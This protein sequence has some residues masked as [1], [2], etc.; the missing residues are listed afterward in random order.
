L[1]VTTRRAFTQALLLFDRVVDGLR[2]NPTIF[3]DEGISAVANARMRGFGRPLKERDTSLDEAIGIHIRRF[4]QLLFE[5]LRKLP[6]AFAAP[7]NSSAFEN[8]DVGRDVALDV[9]FE[10]MLAR[11]EQMVL[12]DLNR[13]ADR[14]SCFMM[15]PC[16]T[17]SIMA[18]RRFIY[19][20][21]R[22]MTAVSS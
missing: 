3:D 21:I 4:R 15:S 11:E 7:E 16:F 10:T 9:L 1:A 6:R 22:G 18:S 2:N 14:R 12:E 17:M 5:Q 13:G 8:D 20:K 19:R